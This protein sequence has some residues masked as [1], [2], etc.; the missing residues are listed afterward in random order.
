VAIVNVIV[1]GVFSAASPNFMQISNMQNILISGA[2]IVLLSVAMAL[3]LAAGELDISLGANLIVSSVVGARAMVALAGT[4][5]Q[6]LAGEYPNAVV[7]LVAGIL[8]AILSGAIFGAVNGI[9]VTRFKISSFIATLG[10]LG[11][12][13]GLARVISNG[14]NVAHVPPMIQ[15]DFG[16]KKYFG[17]PASAILVGAIVTSLWFVLSKTEF[18]LR[19][20][21]I[22]SSR[23]AAVRVGIKVNRY[24]LGLFVLV[25]A[26]A[27][28]AGVIDISRFATTNLSGHE[29]TALSA[30]AG[31]V[32]GGAS[33]WG[34][35]ASIPGAVL[36]AL[37]AVL[38]QNGLLIA[39]FPVFY[40]QIAVGG[41]LIVAV[42]IDQ[43]NTRQNT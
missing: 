42:I 18:G 27:G 43:R 15:D 11:V 39:R 10:M 16:L 12:G 29:A 32:I 4:P 13:S 25:G 1:I 30:I 34:G 20:L 40:Q 8:A 28:L 33:L 9:L 36:G 2:Q 17:I 31:A 5:D 7:A 22:G 38:L 3:L 24:L 37:L 35:R 6:V 23:D 21:A 19:I 14:N 26:M 41:V